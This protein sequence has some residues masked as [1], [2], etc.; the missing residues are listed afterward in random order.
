MITN[1]QC[2]AARALIKLQQSE[3]SVLSG[4]GLSTIKDFE[5]GK[6]ST[7]ERNLEAIQS[8][9]EAKGVIFINPEDNGGAG[10]RLK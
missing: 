8:A 5:S 9:L 7:Y 1:D 10:V 3:L 6:R 2:R 4:I